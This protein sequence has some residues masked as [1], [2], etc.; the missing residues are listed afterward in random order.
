ME[1]VSSEMYR[2][3]ILPGEES[4]SSQILTHAA[5]VSYIRIYQSSILYALEHAT[6]LH[7]LAI[8]VFI[9]SKPVVYLVTSSLALSALPGCGTVLGR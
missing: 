8:I 7:H 2:G 3:N 4:F 6:T 9:D 1:F 5:K